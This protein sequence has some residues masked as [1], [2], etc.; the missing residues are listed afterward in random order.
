LEAVNLDLALWYTA[1]NGQVWDGTLPSMATSRRLCL[2]RCNNLD[3]NNVRVDQR[4]DKSYRSC[5]LLMEPLG[6]LQPERLFEF[7]DYTAYVGWPSELDVGHLQ[8]DDPAG[9]ACC[10]CG[11]LMLESELAVAKGA[12]SMRCGTSCCEQGQVHPPAMPEW[13]AWLVSL[14]M[15]RTGREYGPDGLLRSSLRKYAR[16]IHNALSL[17]SQVG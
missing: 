10:Y 15:G 14:W 13:P 3:R 5:H 16:Q 2:T 7:Q 4:C 6:T 12:P 17:S 1:Y 11:A 9:R 8:W